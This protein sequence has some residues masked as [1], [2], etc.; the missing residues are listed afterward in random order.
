M[1]KLV[2]FN[3]LILI[4][5]TFI[6][7]SCSKDPNPAQGEYGDGVLVINEGAFGQS[8][9]S[10]SFIDRETGE[11][12]NDIY[13]LANNS[14]LLGD[15]AQSLFVQDG[16]AYCIVNGSGKIEV[17]N[18]F[19]FKNKGTIT[20]FEMPRF[21][22]I[23]NDK[24]YVTEWVNFGVNGR[25]SVINLT[26]FT[27]ET[28]IETGI[29]PEKLISIGDKI[30]VPNS[31]DTTIS[32]I[33]T[34]TNIVENEIRVGDW[35]STIIIGS[36]GNLWVFCSGIPS[37]GGGPTNASIHVLNPTNYN[38]QKVIDLGE[39]TDGFAQFIAN[40]DGS[41]FYY[42]INGKIYSISVNAINAPTSPIIQEGTYLYGLGVDPVTG[43][44]Y[45]ADALNFSSNGWV[46]WYTPNGYIIDSVSTGIAPNSFVFI[47]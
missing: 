21:L 38:T 16:N 28:T 6:L 2:K 36:D 3:F 19:D 23:N 39:S 44:I 4:I 35:P 20:G 30:I 34:G 27:I 25:V 40:A 41:E 7:G 10:V 1:K 24:G 22:T 8:N 9:A 5:F 26:N 45:V 42:Q 12:Y 18:V 32:V 29:A 11:V 33:Q 14:L 43:Y 47:D 46:R 37:W 17:V 15:I 31:N 13:S